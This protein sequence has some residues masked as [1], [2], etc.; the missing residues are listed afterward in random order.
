MIIENGR[1]CLGSPEHFSP[2]FQQFAEELYPWRKGPF[3]LY[4]MD[5][6]THWNSDNRWQQAL[7]IMARAG[8]HLEGAN[9][10]D[11]GAG[12]GYYMFRMLENSPG[13]ITGFEPARI[14]L[15]Q[16][17]FLYEVYCD[18]FQQ[19]GKK[20]V[21][22]V[23]PDY[24]KDQRSVRLPDMEMH[25]KG[26]Q[27]LIE[28][29]QAFDVVFCM[30][31]L[32]HQSDPVSLLRL[33]GQSLVKGG[34][35][36]FETLFIE[37]EKPVSLIP[38]ARYAG[39]KGVWNIPSLPAISNWIRRCNLKSICEPIIYSALGEMQRTK[40]ADQPIFEEAI[41]VEQNQTI[42]GYPIPGRVIFALQR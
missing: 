39:M 41:I 21:S 15:R 27:D 17:S 42:E 10:A 28:Y 13:K 18:D 35:L 30:G 4:G 19:R 36:I 7:K 20:W 23:S 2:D 12:N 37:D 9:I 40:W 34:T 6:D 14:F 1:I 5:I 3:R 11:I 16:F 29:Q 8:V 32:Y 26:Y 25:A 24:S 22:E 31:V 38:R 33:C